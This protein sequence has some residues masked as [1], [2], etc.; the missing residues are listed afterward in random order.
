MKRIS[1]LITVLLTIIISSQAQTHLPYRQSFDDVSDFETFTVADENHD[2]Q[3]WTYDDNL[4]VAKSE[5]DYNADEWLI[6]PI[7]EFEKGKTY[8]LTFKAFIEIE[9]EETLSVFMGTGR[10]VSAMTTQLLPE[11][12]VTSSTGQTFKVVFTVDD[13]D[14]YRIGFH[15]CTKDIPYSNYLYLDDINI[16]E[17]VSQAA[18]ASVTNLQVTPAALGELKAT[19]T[20]C[21]PNKTIDGQ[22]LTE[23]TKVDL[24]R[25]DKLIHTFD[26]PA[27]NTVITYEDTQNLTNAKYTYKVIAT[28]KSGSSDPVS[29]S[30]YIGTD[31][32]GPV[33]NLQ[34][35]YDYET[36]KA[37][38]TWD[39]P[40]KGANGGYINPEGIRYTIRRYLEDKNSSI[41]GEISETR[42]E[43]IV[44]IDWLNETAEAKYKEL[45][46]QSGYKVMRTIIIDGQGMYYYVVKAVSDIGQGPETHSNSIVLGDAYTLPY[47]ETFSNG[48]LDHYM[49]MHTTSG[50]SRWSAYADS[51]F[52]QDGDDGFI[53]FA[54]SIID[55]QMSNGKETDMAHTGR[56]CLKGIE[57]PTMT[58]YYLYGFAM[59]NP[60]LIKTSVDGI[61]FKT[62]ATIDL[63]D[64]DKQ[65]KYIRAIVSLKDI[66][67][68]ESAYVGF[69]ATV[70]NTAENILI[71]NIM[72]FDQKDNDL[73]SKI[74]LLPPNL[75]TDEAHNVNVAVHNLGVNNIE[76]G[77]YTVNVFVD[78]MLAG[79]V[80]GPAVNSGEIINVVVPTTATIDM[81]PL[82]S[83]YAELAYNKDEYI[84]NNRSAIQ[85]IKVRLP[86]FPKPENLTAI[87][88]NGSVTLNWK[89]PAA[90]LSEDRTVT[91]GF[92]DY[93]DFTIKN[94]GDW[95]LYD[96]DRRLT[97]S[98][99]EGYMWPNRTLPHAFIV[100]T[101]SEVELTETGGKGL[102]SSWQPHSGLKML[103]SSSSE[104]DDWLISPELSGREQTI[105]FFARATKSYSEKFEFKYSTTDTDINSFKNVGKEITVVGADWKE[106]NFDVPH[107]GRFFAIHKTTKDG[108]MFFI[109]DI[110]FVPDTTAAQ[111]IHLAGYN[112]YRNGIKQNEA[113]LA[114]TSY[115]DN[116]IDADATYKVTAV[117][118]KGESAYSNEAQVTVSDGIT[119]LVSPDIE[120]NVF[121]DLSGR[122]VNIS[123]KGIYI[124]NGRKIILK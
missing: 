51:R 19:I 109:D 64:K 84:D 44:D 123:K 13:T 1:T 24:Y 45:E 92:E 98:F 95:L 5:R 33:L 7:F 37:V 93:E 68:A 86:L 30:A 62:V 75:K 88:N 90:P 71:D 47:E 63:T 38:I 26:Q 87:D 121:Y 114:S 72:I 122:R 6:T 101:P 3:T 96:G 85:N 12:K 17:T 8:L 82:S 16:E 27:V 70:A 35:T 83:I 41:S 32:P 40:T 22:S 20:F 46:E 73:M 104:S 14:D 99:G 25:N 34:A 115:T 81:S 57:N 4:L 91:E 61:N 10:K 106:Y 23:L 76:K 116:R 60:L 120:N 124:Q 54:S 94:F 15:H 79:S 50:V 67:N 58:F 2:N 117:Y 103:M 36:H 43:D 102:S 66:A 105:S 28:N 111:D 110:T 53:G 39:A 118:D 31:I 119:E 18:P 89:A 48:E 112:V 113:L 21:T 55:S 80:Q 97:F 69:E 100:M 108:L 49:L 56:I 11:T 42:F 77:A 59:A 9:D 78:D 29:A 107:G 74:H 65:D 52:S